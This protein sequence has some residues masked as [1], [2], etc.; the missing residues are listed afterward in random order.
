MS[1]QPKIYQLAVGVRWTA[2]ALVLAA[3]TWAGAWSR[4]PVNGWPLIA[5][6]YTTLYLIL[7]TRTLRK[8][9]AR[10]TDGSV[11]VLYDLVLSAI[12]VLLDGGWNS[13]FVL[14]PLSVLVVPAVLRGW[15][16]SLLVAASFLAIDQVVLWATNPNPWQI[17]AQG[18]G[19]TLALLGRTMLPFGVLALVS[20]VAHLVRRLRPARPRPTR[21]TTPRWEYPSMQSLLDSTDDGG[22]AAYGRVGNDEPPVRSWLKEHATQPTLER[23]QPA[24]LQLALQHLA[25]DLKS[26]GVTVTLHLA[27]DEQSL[28]P[29]IHDL[30]LRATE[31]ALDNVLVHAHARSATVTLQILH[32]IVALSVCDDGIGLFDGTAEPPGFHQLKRLRFRAAEL[33]GDLHVEEGDE[34]G[35]ALRLTVPLSR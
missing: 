30:L 13:P 19:A 18:Q 12:P 17:T 4:L 16:A 27:G 11:V 2:Y 21:P 10:T 15:R 32:E 5:L 1:Q 9:L 3:L 35:V 33:G 29:R 34:G 14:M 26:A 25:L 20:A 31:V 24:N 22:S 28:P 8:L 7:W 23:R 6:M